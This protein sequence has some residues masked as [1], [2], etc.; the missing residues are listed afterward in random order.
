MEYLLLGLFS[1]QPVDLRGAIDMGDGSSQ[2]DVLSVVSSSVSCTHTHPSY[3]SVQL[4]FTINSP[5]EKRDSER[6][7]P[8]QHQRRNLRGK[9]QNQLPLS[10]GDITRWMVFITFLTSL[11]PPPPSPPPHTHSLYCLEESLV[12]IK[13]TNSGQRDPSFPWEPATR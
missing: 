8:A 11:C 5:S 6:L 9:V 3:C 13:I 2:L 4:N 7:K 12:S 10:V 1:S